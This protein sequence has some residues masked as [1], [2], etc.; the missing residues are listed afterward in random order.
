MPGAR[1]SEK[2]AEKPSLHGHVGKATPGNNTLHIWG[3]TS[4]GVQYRR[5]ATNMVAAVI[6][7]IVLH[8]YTMNNHR[9][10]VAKPCRLPLGLRLIMNN[11]K[12]VCSVHSRDAAVFL[13]ALIVTHASQTDDK[14]G[15]TEV[16]W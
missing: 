5:H 14:L 8:S 11:I 10:I 4:T 15:I 2:V 3:T 9:G 16:L 13:L 7:A 1:L 6:C 12:G